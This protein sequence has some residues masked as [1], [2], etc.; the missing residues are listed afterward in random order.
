MLQCQYAK[1]KFPVI[2]LTEAQGENRAGNPAVTERK[3]QVSS[4]K[5]FRIMNFE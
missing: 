4:E 3:K 1:F 2:L 5:H